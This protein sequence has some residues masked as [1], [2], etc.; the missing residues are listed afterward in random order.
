MSDFD[1]REVES[2]LRDRKA[3]RPDGSYSVTLMDDPERAAR[4]IVEEAFEVSVE[5][6]RPAVNHDR[7]VEEAADLVFHLLAGLAGAG[8]AFDDVLDEL[9][10]RRS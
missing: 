4:K 3:A 1:L 8:I 7:I 10:R 9:K 6:M 2:V 5:L